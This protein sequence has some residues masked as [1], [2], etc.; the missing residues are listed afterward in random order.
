M[1]AKGVF[2]ATGF[3][4][5]TTGTV[6]SISSTAGK[7]IQTLDEDG[8][9][10]ETSYPLETGDALIVL[11][12]PKARFYTYDS[13]ETADED[14]V[15]YS[16]I[17][18]DDIDAENPGRWVEADSGRSWGS[19]ATVQ[20]ASGVAALSGPGRYKVQVETGAA[21]DL[22]KLTGLE[23]GQEVI[24][25]PD[26]A[27]KPVTVKHGTYIK[28]AGGADFV[29]NNTRDKI[30]LLCEGSDVCSEI[31]RVSVAS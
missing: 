15:N 24:L 1:A 5:G 10:T 6:D 17:R 13:T 21:D 9:V 4:G 31:N 19:A 30:V 3:I 28:L 27:A 26:D 7:V 20:I 16:V 23:D 22:D 29:M 14:A 12:S 8:H 2:V 25:T 11:A 18:P